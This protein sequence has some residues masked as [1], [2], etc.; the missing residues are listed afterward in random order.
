METT[1][2][3]INEIIRV[4]NANLPSDSWDNFSLN[5]WALNKIIEINA[6][7][8]ENG[9]MISF[10]PEANGE[11]I[12]MKIRRLRE[13]F[14]KLSPNKGAWYAC[15]V[16]VYNDGKFNLEFDY[17]KKPGFSYE[18]S[19][20]KFIDDLEKFPRDKDLIPAWLNEI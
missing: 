15:I 11:D 18:P 13:E 3:L 16:T 17:I 8:E 20:D 12:S 9:K 5:I 10:D 1:N 6:F 19:P 4:A 14:Y 7:Y 2:N